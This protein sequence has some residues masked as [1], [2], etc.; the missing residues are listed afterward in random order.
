MN[1]Y[2]LIVFSRLLRIRVFSRE[3]F[4]HFDAR[5]EA[6]SKDD[7][8]ANWEELSFPI[9]MADPIA[10]A[11]EEGV[12]IDEVREEWNEMEMYCVAVIEG[13]HQMYF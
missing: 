7:A 8:L 11:K 5:V 12:S 6:K 4:I 9:I 1:K 2:T 3:Q 13:W 10:D